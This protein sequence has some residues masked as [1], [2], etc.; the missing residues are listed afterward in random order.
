[1]VEQGNEGAIAPL[2][3]WLFGVANLVVLLITIETIRLLLQDIFYPA[4]YCTLP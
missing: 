1:M 3:P 4:G 2:A